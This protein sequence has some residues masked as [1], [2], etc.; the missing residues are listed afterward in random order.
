MRMAPELGR[1]Y[2]GPSV[3]AG[4]PSRDA[5]RAM[6]SWIRVFLLLVVIAT[7]EPWLGPEA[8]GA[9][10]VLECMR[11]WSCSNPA[12][13]NCA[14]EQSRAYSMCEIRCRGKNAPGGTGWGAI[15]YSAR[16]HISGWSYENDYKGTAQ[17]VALQYCNRERG[18]NC[19]I[20]VSFYNSCGAVAAD[21]DTVAS[22]TGST[23][24]GADQKAMS[25]CA[26]AGGK[27]CAVQ[28]AACSGA[29]SGSTT[30]SAPSAPPPPRA[31][32]WG[33]IAYSSKDFGAG[34]ALGK[35]DRAS[36]EKEALSVCA[37]RGRNC[38]LQTAFNKQC[39]ALAA[40]R[41]FFG[42]GTSANQREAQQRA[43]EECRKDGGAR[44]VLHVSFC[45]F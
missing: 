22:G 11:F 24:A 37:Q 8:Y 2:A 23:K 31:I 29:G 39:G 4:T 14:D 45:S 19:V 21:G 27:H 34:W 35:N 28:A 12:G 30:T 36:A 16:D 44:C 40:D 7:A 41:G 33:A 10:C 6:K 25:A 18:A 43:I 42:W 13:Q 17:Q 1:V 20:R 15:A 32:S 9:S 3:P 38:V 26:L 5:G